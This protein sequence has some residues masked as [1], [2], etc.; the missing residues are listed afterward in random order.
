MPIK[1][2]KWLKLFSLFLPLLSHF[3]KKLL[4]MNSSFVRLV[5]SSREI[6]SCELSHED[7]PGKYT[8]F[9]TFHYNRIS[10]DISIKWCY[11]C[12]LS[13][14]VRLKESFKFLQ[15]CGRL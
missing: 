1:P 15:L 14:V 5:S 10:G 4:E 11:Q 6:V 7:S 12:P 3:L 2:L 13:L 9:G 8:I